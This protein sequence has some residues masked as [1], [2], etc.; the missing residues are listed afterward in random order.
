[1]NE[2]NHY[3]ISRI[4][5]SDV[6]AIGGARFG[7]FGLLRSAAEALKT[8]T[9]SGRLSDECSESPSLNDDRLIVQAFEDV[10]DGAAPDRILWDKKLAGDFK[11]R[12]RELALRFSS[13]ALKKRLLNVRKNSPRYAKHGIVILPT[14]KHEPHPSV[15]PQYAH[16]IEFALVRLRYRYGASIDD[17]LLDDEMGEKFE[18]LALSMAPALSASEVRLGAL[19]IRKTRHFAKK[20]LTAFQALD[21]REIANDWSQPIYLTNALEVVVPSTPGLIE[22]REDGRSLYVSRTENVAPAVSEIQTGKPFEIM[23]GPFWSPN[24]DRI[25]VRFIAGEKIHGTAAHKW[26][27]RLIAS[28][29]PVF[30]WPI[31]KVA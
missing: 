17:I 9:P 11:R 28:N 19:Y 31:R 20:D 13:T 6:K 8:R 2:L 22:V 29:E 1:M 15:V 18:E 10:R 14:T 26:E 23:S 24:P 12:C 27:L 16:A 7:G 30:N 21:P 4:L 25:S 5:G 3:A